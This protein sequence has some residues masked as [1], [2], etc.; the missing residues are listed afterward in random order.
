MR[1]HAHGLRRT[2][3]RRPSVRQCVVVVAHGLVRCYARPLRRVAHTS[4]KNAREGIATEDKATNSLDISAARRPVS[5]GL[6]S[7]GYGRF[8][9]DSR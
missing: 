1:T 7:Q 8:H 9:R 2:D 5:L 3:R 6:R 4:K